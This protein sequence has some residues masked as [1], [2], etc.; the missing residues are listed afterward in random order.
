MLARRPGSHSRQAMATWLRQRYASDAELE[1]AWD[2]IV[3]GFDDVTDKLLP[4]LTE[5]SQQAAEDC[6]QFSKRLVEKLISATSAAARTVA[7]HHLNLGNR[8]AWI[9]SDLAYAGSEHLDVF[10]INCYARQPDLELIETIRE[11]TGKPVIIGEW[12]FG[13]VDRG[14]LGSGLQAVPSQAERGLA[15]RGFCE[16]AAST[17]GLV[18]AHW[19]QLYDQA[20]LGRFDGENWNIGLLDI[21]SRPYPE[22]VAGAR[23]SHE[24]LYDLV[25]GDVEPIQERPAESAKIAN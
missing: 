4:A 25:Y 20:P 3:T 2:S 6:W 23:A 17:I 22:L 11:H 10:S 1:Q 15:Y 12:H 8:W 16:T 13:A 21:C 14:P 7:P 5:K 24:R 9:A 19:F 18:G